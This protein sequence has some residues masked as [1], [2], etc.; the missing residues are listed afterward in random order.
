MIVPRNP[1]LIAFSRKMIMFFV[2]IAF[3]LPVLLGICGVMLPAMGYFPALGFEQLSFGPARQFL[4]TPGIVAAGWLSVKTGILATALSLVCCF[5]ILIGVTNSRA[6][7]LM[8]RWLGPLVAVP[9][10]AMAIGLLFLLAPS[11]WLMRLL[12]PAVTGFEQPPDWSLVPDPHGWLLVFGLMAKET[13]FLVMV[14]L[15]AIATLPTLKLQHIGN[16][17][18]YS[19]L[20][21]WGLLILPLVYRQIRLP[22]VAVLVFSLSVVDMALL[23]APSLPPPL[24]ILVLHGFLDADL[25][26]R[27]PAS[28]GALVQIGIGIGGVAIWLLVEFLFSCLTNT[29]RRRGWRLGIADKLLPLLVGAA[30]VPLVAASAGLGAAFLWSVAGSW[31]FPNAFP[32]K[33]HFL[34]WQDYA[35]YLPLFKNSVWLASAATLSAIFVVLLWLYTAPR[36]ALPTK[37]LVGML[38]LPFFIPQISF[39]LGMQISLSRFGLDGT[40]LAVIWAHVIFILPYIWFILAPAHRAL[41]T[42]FDDIAATLGAAPWQRFWRLHLPLMAYPLGAAVF[43]GMSV[44]VALY[45]PT[46]FVGSGRINSIT[47]EAVSLAAGGS[48]GPAGVAAMLQIAIPLLSLTLIHLAL[49]WRFSR[50]SGMHSGGLQ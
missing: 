20:A 45:L 14:S 48:R 3:G 43:I 28:V 38:Y 44:S 13:P 32:Q 33:L 15:G 10:S 23:L 7:P 29:M 2:M 18:G 9:H 24:A 50:F 5:V 47:V 6:L 11:G 36:H 35:G 25:A 21:A 37:W 30:F 42:R 22:V 34:H 49:R 12:S 41:D 4:E 31:F 39:L 17:L 26:A 8:R 19:R 40:W 1:L 27:L 46:L 16:S